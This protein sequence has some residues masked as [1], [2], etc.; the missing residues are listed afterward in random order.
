MKLR[1]R[2]IITAAVLVVVAAALAWAIWARLGNGE[3][4]E[5]GG[6]PAAPVAVATVERGT[7]RDIQS[8]GGT[9]ESRASVTIA[10]K[11]GGRVESLSADFAD[12]VTRGQTVAT[13]DSAEYA[14]DVAAANAD[15][16]VAQANVTE[17]TSAQE[18]AQREL[19]RVR[20]LQERG[21]SSEAQFDT[22]SAAALASDAR[23]EVANAELQRAQAALE[24]ATVRLGY[25]TVAA[26]WSG[27]DDARVVAER[28]VEE[29]DTVAANTP[30]MTIVELDRLRA[31]LFVVERDYARLQA[32]QAVTLTT[33]AHPGREFEA[34]V[35]RVSPVFDANSRQARV[36]LAVPNDDRALRP[37]LFVRARATL[38]E[39]EG[40][41]T[42]PEAALTRRGGE[43]SLFVLGDDGNVRLVPVTPGIREGERV[44]LLE[45]DGVGEGDRVVT[46]GQ[47]LLDDGSAAVVPEE[48]DGEASREAE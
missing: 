15:L 5:R 43:T 20:T 40:V 44:Q 25:A 17:A 26:E 2:P 30:L 34:T 38:A 1:P 32:G 35:D 37:G 42:V 4:Q 14:A 10:A 8:F 21:V 47:Q 18:I 23:V 33:D 29:G 9:L 3:E 27:G 31:V 11:V 48:D 36:E 39:A 22:A 12:E 46:L 28:F 41:L 13:L 7:I 19:G 16:A 24:S 6:P 45:A